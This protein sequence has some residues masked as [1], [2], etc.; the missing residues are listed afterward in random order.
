MLKD[1]LQVRRDA[2]PE[3]ATREDMVAIKTSIV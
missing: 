2:T 3:R 1:Q